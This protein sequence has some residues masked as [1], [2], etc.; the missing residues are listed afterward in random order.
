MNAIEKRIA[1]QIGALLIDNA[2]LAT[3]A[4][5]QNAEIIRLKAELAKLS[6][7]TLPLQNGNGSA[8]YRSAKEASAVTEKTS[9]PSGP[10]PE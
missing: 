10:E 6:E 5:M 2:K 1:E 3:Q 8:A 7:P 9:T 4:E